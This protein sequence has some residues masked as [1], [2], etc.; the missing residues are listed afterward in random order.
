M[1]DFIYP[2]YW[3]NPDWLDDSIVDNEME[4]SG[5][6]WDYDYE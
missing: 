4:D 6:E 5:L 1:N 2:S 3:D